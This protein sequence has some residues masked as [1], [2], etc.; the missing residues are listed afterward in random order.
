MHQGPKGAEGVPIPHSAQ[1]ERMDDLP[2]AQAFCG[3]RKH[4]ESPQFTTG[5]PSCC[6]G[7]AS[8]AS[9]W[10]LQ[11]PALARVTA[12]VPSRPG[13]L[14]GLS[15]SGPLED[16]CEDTVP[17]V[18]DLRKH[19]NAAGCF[20]FS[21]QPRKWWLVAAHLCQPQE[22]L[23]VGG[24]RGQAGGRRPCRPATCL[25]SFS[26]QPAGGGRRGCPPA[27]AK[28]SFSLC[29]FPLLCKPLGFLPC[30]LPERT[31]HLASRGSC[32]GICE[33]RVR[34]GAAAAVLCAGR[35]EGGRSPRP[36]PPRPP[37]LPPPAPPL[38]RS[39]ALLLSPLQSRCSRGGPEL[40]LPPSSE[41]VVHRLEGRVRARLGP[42]AQ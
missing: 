19:P 22:V 41:R 7:N 4:Q 40:D 32:A 27:L 29:S 35:G 16:S 39:S 24:Q 8:R 26:G 25:F 11:R 18:S 9:R 6:V 12:W 10:P 1:H 13:H 23:P 37:A 42:E 5:S 31:L 33:D 2:L 34:S 36:A 3:I 14:Q 28:C 20:P 15:L 21:G 30:S 38:P 17:G